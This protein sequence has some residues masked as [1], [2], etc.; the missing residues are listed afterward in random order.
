[1]TEDLELEALDLQALVPLAAKELKRRF[2]NDPESLPGTFVI[3]LFL[4]GHR[5]LV[6]QD[7]GVDVEAE[8]EPDVLDLVQSPGLPLERKLELLESEGQKCRDRLADINAAI[9]TLEAE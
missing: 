5:Q 1:M 2:E 8:Q 7:E 6:R 4:D 9:E 3:K